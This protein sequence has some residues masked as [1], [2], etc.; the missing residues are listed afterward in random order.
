MFILVS[1]SSRHFQ[2]LDTNKVLHQFEPCESIDVSIY[3][4]WR[5]AGERNKKVDFFSISVSIFTIFI[6]I[7]IY[8]DYL[9]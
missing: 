3:E 2:I 5:D 7:I 6:I 1:S 4:A 9:G 8:F